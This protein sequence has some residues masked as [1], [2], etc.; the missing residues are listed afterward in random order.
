MYSTT[1]RGFTLAEILVALGIIGLLSSIL[2]ASV[3]ESRANARDKVRE[4]DRAQIQLAVRLYQEQ[5]GESPD[6]G[7][8]CRSCGTEA[9]SINAAVQ[10][11]I[12]T[13]ED[14]NQSADYYYSYDGSQVCVQFERDEVGTRD[15]IA[16][17]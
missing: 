10:S 14:P 17:R 7:N 5:T 6:P 12:G 2:I 11:F 1:T 13:I 16:V 8:V 4:T 15:C 9:G 3:T